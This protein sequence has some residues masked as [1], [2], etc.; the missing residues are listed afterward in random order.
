MTKQNRE[1]MLRVEGMERKKTTQTNWTLG[2][3]NLDALGSEM[4]VFLVKLAACMSDRT[5]CRQLQHLSWENRAHSVTHQGTRHCGHLRR[6]E[7]TMQHHCVGG[8][9]AN[10]VAGTGAKEVILLKI[11]FDKDTCSRDMQR[12]FMA[13]C[14]LFLFF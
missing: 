3:E 7:T 13:G 12:L 6:A 4:E 11:Q 10:E 8:H 2:L 5:N 9:R 14:P 1:E